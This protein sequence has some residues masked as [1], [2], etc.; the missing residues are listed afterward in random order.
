VSGADKTAQAVAFYSRHPISA[1]Q[2]LARL[3]AQRGGLDGLAPEDLFDHDQDHYGGLAANDAMA[4]LAH[5][6]EG[7]RVADFC[8][9]LG[10][11]ARYLAVR[12][13]ATVTGVELTP[14]RV[15][16]AGEL[17]RLVGLADRVRVLHGDVTAAPL[18]DAS[19][20]AVVSQEAML[21]VPDKA[22]AIREAFRVLVP[23]GRLAFSDWVVHRPLDDADAD[24]MWRGMAVQT[25]QSLESYRSLI[26]A[27]GFTVES[28]EDLTAAWGP[29]LEERFA[30]YRALREETVKA[31]TPSGDDAFY[32]S[33]ERLVALVRDGT[34]GGGRFAAVK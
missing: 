16:G 20:D 1:A 33:Y 6:G 27:A 24:I 15:E 28:V 19:M 25:L 2:I 10:G 13:G 3:K 26:A 29:I 17:S 23:G 31:G 11:P 14:A 18:A 32:L 30:M 5:I 21:H 4:R 7:S 8:A 34:L 22:Q 12:Y 9:G